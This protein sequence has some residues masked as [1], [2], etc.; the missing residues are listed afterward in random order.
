M[1][2]D[3]PLDAAAELDAEQ[4]VL[5]SREA[6]GKIIRG[7]A[8]RTLAYAGGIL[9]GLASTPLMVRHLGVEDF[10]RFV[11][12]GSLIFIIT[13]LTEGGLSAIGV[14]EY[15]TGDGPHR[16]RLV[17][18]LLGLRA[19]LTVVAVI[20][21]VLFAVAAGYDDVMLTGVLISGV[22]LA[23]ANWFFVYVV[24]MTAWL[25]LGWLA[26]LDLLR[27]ALTSVV[28]V[29]LVI[30]GAGLTWFFVAA[31][32][33]TAVALVAIWLLVRGRAP[34]R[35]AWDTREWWRLLRDS[36]PY[37][38]AL[39]IAVLYFRVGVILSS[40]ISSEA[41]T[42]YYAL[43]FRIVEI[44]SGVPWI[45]ASSAFPL[46]SRAVAHDHARFRYAL[47]RTYEVSLI[48]GVWVAIAIGL[49]S[50]FAVEVI[51]GDDFKPS[52]DVLTVLGVAMI[53]TFLLACWGH[54]LLTLR[55]HFALLWA[56]LSAFVVGTALAIVLI[57]NHGALGAAIA[58]SVTE[59]WLACVYLVL[60]TRTSADLRPRLS[61]LGPVALAAAVAL[62]PPLLLGFPSVVSV[63]FATVAFFG[64][65]AAMGQIPRELLDAARLPRSSRA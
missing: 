34:G 45:L 21:A 26:L 39:A 8:A 53:G 9:L 51:G 22:G 55:R 42:G 61:L 10:G 48:L 43:A 11:T 60:L 7:G 23:L 30:A 44:V 17:R 58:T 3:G 47:G 13:G 56:N 2:T 16:D 37:A 27:Q 14:R 33:A 31:P 50:P 41:E 62:A 24:P 38:A 4:D 12:V 64:V 59:L 19:A 63:A 15:S 36:L 46:F 65:L 35:P 5:D 25:R 54:G 32:L 40:L 18:N 1:T 57:S 28:V 6:G 49:G 52:V 20:S 29:A